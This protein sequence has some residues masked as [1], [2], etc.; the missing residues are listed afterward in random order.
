MGYL[1][2]KIKIRDCP[3]IKQIIWKREREFLKKGWEKLNLQTQKLRFKS[4][5]P[6]DA[7]APTFDTILK[8]KKKTFGDF[9]QFDYFFMLSKKTYF[10]KKT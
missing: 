1:C 2:S 8:E 5:L 4:S 10:T 6:L 7:N 9:G 3:E